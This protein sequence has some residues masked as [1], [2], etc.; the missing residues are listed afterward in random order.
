MSLKVYSGAKGELVDFVPLEDN[1]VKMYVCGPTVYNYIH[2]GNARPFI[3]FDTVRKYLK[4]RGY[5]V[6]YIQNITDIDDKMINKANELGITVK[7]LADK[8]SAAYLEDIKALNIETADVIPKATEHIESI[9]TMVSKLIEKEYAYLIDGS[10]YYDVS[11]FAG[12]G[13]LSRQDMEEI[14]HGSRVDVDVEKRN[15]ADF[16]LWKAAKPGEPSWDSPWGKGRP[17]WHIECS[18]MSAEYFGPQFDIH[19]GGIDLMFPHHENEVAQS[20]AASGV[21]PS[22][23][24]WLHNGFIT[25]DKEKMSKSL[26]NMVLCRDM[27]DKYGGETVRLYMLSGHFRVPLNFSED[28]IVQASQGLK[29]LYN[30]TDRLE[31]MLE[32]ASAYP[33]DNDK[34][35]MNSLQVYRDSFI[36]SMDNDFNTPQAIAVLYNLAKDANMYLD[37][38]GDKISADLINHTLNLFSEFGAVLGILRNIR[39]KESLPEDLMLLIREREEARRRK[40]WSRSDQIRDTLNSHGIRL[41]DTPYGVQWTKTVS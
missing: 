16:A 7:E 26:G 13:K 6:T 3:V 15:P 38:S 35:F 32:V 22:V 24:Y 39:K 31:N 40:D 18:A 17:G 12:Y 21:S 1:K 14:Q 30:V 36:E 4:Y 2:I 37:N 23:K 27:V 25:M 29:R 34:K 5:K 28:L 8:F 33:S 20:E 41:N 11:K 19:A 9:I 10:V